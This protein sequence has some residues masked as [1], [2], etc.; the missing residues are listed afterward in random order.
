MTKNAD[1]AWTHNGRRPWNLC[2]FGAGR[3]ASER[4]TFAKAM[5]GRRRLRQGYG[6][7]ANQAEKF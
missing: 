3:S 7:Q 6:G 2:G 1:P 5:V 4:P